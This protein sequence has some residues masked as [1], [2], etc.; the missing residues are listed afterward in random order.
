M[1]INRTQMTQMIMIN[2]DFTRLL[3]GK[4]AKIITICVIS[5]PLLNW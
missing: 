2:Y 4:S 5:V 1:N 3:A